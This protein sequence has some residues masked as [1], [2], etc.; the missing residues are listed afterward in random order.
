[1][2]FL[3]RLPQSLFGNQFLYKQS[4]HL[5]S[6]IITCWLWPLVLLHAP[7]I[8]LFF[9]FLWAISWT[10]IW[11]QKKKSSL[12]KHRRREGAADWGH[13]HAD[14]R[15]RL[16]ERLV[17]YRAA[18]QNKYIYMTRA[19]LHYQRELQMLT[20]RHSNEAHRQ[21]QWRPPANSVFSMDRCRRRLQ[22]V[23]T[24]SAQFRKGSGIVTS[25]QQGT[26]PQS[27]WTGIQSFTEMA[28]FQVSARSSV[29]LRM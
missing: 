28:S 1:M 18:N 29:E 22:H 15:V 16:G 7:N 17:T 5:F 2:L 12:C 10:I 25:E 26:C 24:S 9:F 14:E 19:N 4:S 13:Q 3:P 23:H 20:K 6:S 8:G 27:P 21:L 11:G